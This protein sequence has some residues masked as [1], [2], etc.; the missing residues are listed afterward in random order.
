[1]N[2]PVVILVLIV[3]LCIIYYF[4]RGSYFTGKLDKKYTREQLVKNFNEHENDFTEL[5]MLFNTYV[6]KKK[7]YNVSFG[8][9]NGGRISLVLKPTVID[10]ASKIIGGEDLELGSAK[11]DTAL[12][13]LGWTKDTA[14]KIAE[15][16]DRIKC[17]WIRTTEIYANP[18]EIYPN[19]KGWGS[20][21]YRVFEYPLSDSLIQIHG[22]PISNS[23]LGKRT[24]IDYSS[25]L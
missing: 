10:P 23:D 24:F 5:V 1:M 4:Y 9:G 7:E 13:S 20:F 25:A 6:Y 3:V 12:L 8:L 21:T 2:K 18:I 11:L 19:Q 15:K 14:K 16:L 22:R 17:D